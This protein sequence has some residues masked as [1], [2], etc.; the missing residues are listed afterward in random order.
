M[1]S[2]PLGATRYFRSE[3]FSTVP[4][5]QKRDH[6]LRCDVWS[7]IH[8]LDGALTLVAEKSVLGNVVH[9]GELV[10]VAPGMLHH[11]EPSASDLRFVVHLYRVVP[12]STRNDLARWENEGGALR[13]WSSSPGAS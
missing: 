13:S 3:V 5:G 9:A 10:D 11:L 6:R 8:V 4:Q 12:D 7:R 2:L 1:S